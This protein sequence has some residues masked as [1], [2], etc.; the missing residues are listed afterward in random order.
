MV[1][2]ASLQRYSLVCYS[3]E[4]VKR[5]PAMKTS[6]NPSSTCWKY[7]FLGG[8]HQRSDRNNGFTAADG[9]SCHSVLHVRF[10]AQHIADVRQ[11]T[12]KSWQ[13]CACRLLDERRE[14]SALEF[15][16]AQAHLTSHVTRLSRGSW[17][18][19]SSRRQACATVCLSPVSASSAT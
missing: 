7:C 8:G 2:A 15:V 11:N 1:G 18:T 14:T 10:R 4:T 16:V 19:S 13:C 17:C 9:S 3:Q 12:W 6:L 5:H